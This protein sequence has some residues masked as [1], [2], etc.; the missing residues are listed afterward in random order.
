M[1]VESDLALDIRQALQAVAQVEAAVASATQARLTVDVTAVAP[2]ISG[3]VDAADTNVVVTGDAAEL[4]GDVT[5]AVDAGDSQVTVTGDASELTGDVTAAVDAGDSQVT[6]TG[7]AT[8]VTGSIDGAVDAADSHVEVTADAPDVTGSINAAVAAADTKVTIDADDGGSLGVLADHLDDVN[9]GLI[10]A[11]GSGV[12]LRGV[13]QAI[14]AAGLGVGLFQAAQSASDLAESTSKASVV[15]GDA[16]GQVREFGETSAQSIGLSEQAALEATGTF[17]NL[18]VALGTT[19]Q[20]AADLAPDVVQLA[21]DLASFN[22][23][24]LDETLEKLRSGLV[25]EVEPLR[26]LGVSFNAAQVDAK[27]MEL[28]LVDANG[29]IS[30]GAKLQARWKLILEQTGTAQ[31]DFARTSEGLANQQRILSAEF[32]NAVASLG[33]LL[34]PALL[35][36]VDITRR[37]LIPAFSELAESVLP[38]LANIFVS[39]LPVAGGFINLLVAMAPIIE[40]VASAVASVPPELITLIGLMV[41][42]KRLGG[43][44][45]FSGLVSGFKNLADPTKGPGGFTSSLKASVG[46]MIAANAVSIGLSLGIAAIGLAFEE[47][48]QEAAEFR[49]Q[50]QQIR[51][52]LDDALKPGTDVAD[53]L[54]D[55]FDKLVEAGDNASVILAH[56]GVTGDEFAQTVAKNT[57]RTEAWAHQLGLT[58][59]TLGIL[60]PFLDTFSDQLD[61]AAKQ[62]VDQ[63]R[64]GGDLSDSFID[65]AVA[66]QTQTDAYLGMTIS[67]TDYVGVLGTLVEAQNEAAEKIGTTVD[68][69]GKLV[70]ATGPAADAANALALGLQLVKDH[71]GDLGLELTNLGIAAGDAKVAEEDLQNVADSLGVSLDDLK[72]FVS[73]V[74]EA[75]NQFADDALSTIPSVG[76][77]IGDLGE[78]FSPDALL[79]KLTEAT[80]AIAGF[81]D[82]L[83]SLAAFPRVQQIA[84]ENGPLVAAAL[85]KPVDDG[86]TEILQQLEDQAAA[87]DLH[88]AGLDDQLRNDLGPK[89]ADATGVTAAAATDAFGENFNPEEQATI[90]THGTQ[91]AIANATPQLH[92]AAEEFGNQGTAG[93]ST[94]VGGMPI[95]AT[96]ASGDSISAINARNFAANLA[97]TLFGRGIADPFADSVG[98]MPVATSDSARKSVNAVNAQGPFASLAGSIFGNSFAIG[99]ASGSKGMSSAAGGAADAAVSKV[100]SKAKSASGA[101]FSVGLAMGSGMQA[102]INSAAASVGAAAAAMVQNAIDKAKA[103][104]QVGSP[105]KLFAELGRDMADGV[106][107]GLVDGTSDV[108]DAAAALVDTA[109]TVS[110]DTL[111]VDVRRFGDNGGL[112][113]G[114]VVVQGVEGMFQVVLPPGFD[115]AQAPAT[116]AGIARGFWGYLQQQQVRTIARSQV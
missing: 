78:N 31:G 114:T 89:L 5:A 41:S 51:T 86:N 30:E 87:Y 7:D 72:S 77:I 24:A 99:T 65:Q 90:A 26:S 38:A 33:Q 84:A 79:D 54:A 98:K 96:Q 73:Q 105:S 10:A 57:D 50:V 58:A 93:F 55:T 23:L 32:Q 17:G 2:A 102:G 42:V 95:A 97:G 14:S 8:E 15:F 104:A 111:A 45:L 43:S 109:A 53:A 113:A 88:Y 4:T 22:N 70:Q 37:D 91:I 3:A 115:P 112:A 9:L 49:R 61:L 52:A 11:S 101:G 47:Q 67:S 103:K 60:K 59:D 35:D 13:I 40:A 110:A 29:E 44:D 108:S 107:V 12:R 76:D 94:G 21:G 100:A 63:I 19:K 81:S 116:G 25:G 27:A 28:G 34:L 36:G 68:E 39:L 18:F 16:I 64:A 92:S 1:S 74:N 85:A 106:T 75:V 62:Q 20:Q 82:N 56:A 66:A 6:V 69:T 46:E 80:D 48:A 83:E 71:G